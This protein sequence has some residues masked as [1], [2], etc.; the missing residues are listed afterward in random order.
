[1]T[2]RWFKNHDSPRPKGVC[3]WWVMDTMA[4]AFDAL[5]IAA[6]FCAL[7]THGGIAAQEAAESGTGEGQCQWACRWAVDGR[8]CDSARACTVCSKCRGPGRAARRTV[9]V[10]APRRAPRRGTGRDSTCVAAVDAFLR[11]ID[12]FQRNFVSYNATQD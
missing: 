7:Q 8:V 2:A 3:G 1:M 5:G 4:H 6:A 9:A 11:W 12:G 10:P